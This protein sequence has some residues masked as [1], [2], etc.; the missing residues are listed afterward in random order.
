MLKIN[1]FNQY[2]EVNDYKKIIKYILKQAVKVLRIKERMIVNVILVDN[3][4]IQELNNGYRNIDK[5]T[6]VLSFVNDS[7]DK[8]IG[9]IFISLDKTKE[10]ALT[11][12]HSF[13]R[14]LAFLVTHGF[15]HCLGYDHLTEAD[16]LE[17]FDLQNKILN[18]SI[19]GRSS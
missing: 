8:E 3:H 6:D 19:H 17:M 12:G 7:Y 5:P 4:K 16:E 14:E 9:D 2:D 1:I 11:Y 13:A 10:Q 18:S 15:L